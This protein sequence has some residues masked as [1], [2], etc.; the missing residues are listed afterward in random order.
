[1]L[2][3]CHPST[4]LCIAVDLTGEK[5]FIKTRPVSDWKNNKPD[6]HKRPA[7]FLLQAV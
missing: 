7:I 5:E 2:S 3:G 6:I 4:R 1:L